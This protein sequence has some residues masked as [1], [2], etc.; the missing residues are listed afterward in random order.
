MIGKSINN[1][2]FALNTDEPISPGDCEGG[3]SRKVDDK[4]FFICFE[5]IRAVA[6]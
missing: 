6:G 5:T 3:R 1:R 4:N 2:R